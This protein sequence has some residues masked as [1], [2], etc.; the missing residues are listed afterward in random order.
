MT[1]RASVARFYLDREVPGMGR[2]CV[3]TGAADEREHRAGLRLFA[4]LLHDHRAD[5]VDAVVTQSL[6]LAHLVRLERQGML[7]WAMADVR[8]REPLWAT[9]ER[10]F[11]AA[12]KPSFRNYQRSFRR[13]KAVGVL[14]AN[15]TVRQLSTVDWRRLEMAWPNKS[16]ANWN[17]LRRAVSA[18]LTEVCGN[19]HHPFRLQVVNKKS[20]PIRRERPRVPQVEVPELVAADLPP[21]VRAVAIGC[22][23]LNLRPGEYFRLRPHHWHPE[24]L[25]LHV[26]G[27][28]TEGSERWV[29]VK[30]A[31]APLVV[32]VIEA[33]LPPPMSYRR[34]ADLW[35]ETMAKAGMPQVQMRDMRH[36]AAGWQL[37]AGAALHTVQ[38]IMG[39]TNPRQ[40][41]DYAKRRGHLLPSPRKAFTLKKGA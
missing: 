36:L 31:D 24:R 2:V 4:Q 8:L 9:V 15:A 1:R 19:V 27:T 26:P 16:G 30:P 18:L 14:P 28:K 41:M 22:A 35:R 11:P 23:M 12:G 17:H 6:T 39:H 3:P 37:D 21:L 34:F 29:R 5:L 38:Q 7:G 40:T 25:T 32:P 13:L 10:I 33:M 20:F